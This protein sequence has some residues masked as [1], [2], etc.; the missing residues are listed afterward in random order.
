MKADVGLSSLG[1]LLDFLGVENNDPAFN[2][3]R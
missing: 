3:D 1:P 2:Y